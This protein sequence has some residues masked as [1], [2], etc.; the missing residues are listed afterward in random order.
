MA[1]RNS[2]HLGL[3]GFGAAYL[4]TGDDKWLDPWRKMIDKVNAQGKK[5]DG[6]LMT[7]PHMYG[8]NGWYDYKPE[9]YRHGA[10]EIWY[11]S[12]R[13]ADL[14][15]LSEGGWVGFLQ[16]KNPN[17]PEQALRQDLETIRKK[18][19]SIKADTTTPDT[20]LADDSMRFNPATVANLVHLAFGG[21]HHGNRTLVL[22]TRV[23]YFDPAKRRPG[24]PA[25]VAAL[26]E[27]MTA[28]ETV[29]TLV[30]VSPIHTRRVIVQ[31]GAYGEHQF[32]TATAGDAT[33]TVNGRHLEVE[34]APGA[35]AQIKFGTKRYAHAPT[36][37]WPW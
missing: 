33:L 11:W 8:D 35:G 5:G 22:H 17:Y 20:R 9:K 12:M 15:R 4:L 18:V 23:R 29:L 7:Y 24:L 34:L 25:D 31:A 36:L 19:A 2:H 37:D 21:L 30:N 27:K 3:T 13:D 16:G 14:A 1:H 6:G 10:E 32:T 26:V 28:D